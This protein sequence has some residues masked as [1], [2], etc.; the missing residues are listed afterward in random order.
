[1]R[2]I[3]PLAFVLLVLTANAGWAQRLADQPGYVPIEKLD[4]FPADKL[5]VEINLEGALLK[6]IAAGARAEDPEFSSLIDG[7]KGITVQAVPLKD[8]DAGS[9][10]AKIGQASRWLED[11]G[12]KSTMRVREEGTETYI[13]LKE[14]DGAIAG[15]TLLALEPGDEAVA[16]NIVGRIDPE[17]VGRVV[18]NLHGP[19]IK[20]VPASGKK[21]E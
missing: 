8:V 18:E 19:H 1:M 2:K 10:R 15:L 21:P 4:L 12:W 9:V 5:N 13:Y 6:L 11:R 16:I 20:R 7:L 3:I 17:Q 14:I